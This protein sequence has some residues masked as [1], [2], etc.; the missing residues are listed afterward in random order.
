MY[1]CICKGITERQVKAAVDD[2]CTSLRELRAE[3][4]VASNCGKCA[5]HV[6]DVLNEALATSAVVPQVGYFQ[7]QPQP[8]AV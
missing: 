5:C 6:R 3:L 1:V 4:G 2:G 8:V 7:P